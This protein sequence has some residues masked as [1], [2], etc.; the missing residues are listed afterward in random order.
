MQWHTDWVIL[1]T[2]VLQCHVV[3]P[4]SPQGLA[5]PPIWDTLDPSKVMHGPE[6]LQW[7]LMQWMFQNM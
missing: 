6:M 5:P 2:N 4:L 7:T 3:E 1:H